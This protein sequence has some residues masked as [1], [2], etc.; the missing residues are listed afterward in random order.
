LPCAAECAKYLC[1]YLANARLYLIGVA[2]SSVNMAEP[3]V[4]QK[5]PGRFDK[6]EDKVP[7]AVGYRAGNSGIKSWGFECPTPGNLEPGVGVSDRFKLYLD[8]DFLQ[9]MSRGRPQFAAGTHE[10]VQT[11]VEDFLKA[12]YNHIVTQLSSHFHLTDW[13]STTIHYVFSVPTKW[14]GRAVARDVE[15]IVRRSGFGQGGPNHFVEFDLTEAE[16][17][18]VYTARSSKHQ[19]LAGFLDDGVESAARA[20]TEGPSLQEGHVLLVCDSG[21]GTTVRF[22]YDI[23]A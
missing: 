7:T 4:I 14:D 2:F 12:L 3:L 13:N 23:L 11:W 19:R 18:A 16:A 6:I 1:D 21:G 10:D 15:K 20:S 17:A 22:P 8:N 5:W 9:D